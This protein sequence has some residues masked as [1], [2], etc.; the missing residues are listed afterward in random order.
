MRERVLI[1]S[2]AVVA[3]LGEEAFG[4]AP[5]DWD[6]LAL[7]KGGPR[8]DVVLG[9]GLLDRYPFQ[10]EVA[11]VDEVYTLKVSHSP[12]VVTSHSTWMKH[13]RDVRVLRD[14]GAQVV[15]ALHEVAYAEWERRQ[16]AKRVNLRQ[17]KE[18]FFASGVRRLYDHDSVHAAVAFGERPLFQ[19]ILKPGEEVLTSRAL[20][21]KLPLLRQRQ[22]AQEEVMVLSLE[23]DLIPRH[24]RSGQE[25]QKRDLFTSYQRQLHLLITQY[26]K[27]WFPR[28]IIEHYW[29]VAQPPFNYWACFQESPRKV[30]L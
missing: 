19:A 9:T 26:S 14:S 16:G 17:D 30:R 15:E 24:E 1:G 11:T 21:E 6:Y 5:G 13:L 28:W 23:R 3:R 27:G 22:L 2:Q 29:E 10:E 8:E 12:W 18:A 4:R 25:P 20:F 7:T